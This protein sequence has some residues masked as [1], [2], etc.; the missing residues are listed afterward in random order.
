MRDALTSGYGAAGLRGDVLAGLVV[1]VVAL[2][3]SMGLA[4]ASGVAPQHGLYTAIVAGGLIALLGGSRVQVSGPTA[5]FVV[6]LSP[7]AARLGLS[8]LLMSTLLAGLL[9]MA[10]GVARLGKWIEY[11]PYPVTI[12]FTAGIAVVIATLQLEGLLALDVPSMPEHFVERVG[13]LA[14]ALPTLHV[15]DLAIGALTL[16]VLVVWPRV[17]RK[18]PAPLVALIVA[19]LAAVA[20]H[21]VL[22]EFDVVTIADRFGSTASDGTPSAGIP[23]LLPPFVLPWDLPGAHG[24]QFA[25][26]WSVL[27]TLMPSAFAIAMLGA[28][29]SLLSAVVADGMIGSAHDPDAELFAQGVGNF[30]APFFGGIAA[31]GAI[32]RTATNVRSGARSPLAAVVHALVV[33]LA[34]LA[35]AP[36]LGHLP[37]A[38]LSALLLMVA[39]NMSEAK[40]FVHTLRTSPA[41]DVVVLLSCFGLTVAF[42]MVVS[43]SVG[44]VLASLLFMKRM[45][46]LAEVRMVEEHHPLLDRKL[47]EEVVYYEIA[48]P[49]FFGAAHRATSALHV[50]HDRAKAVVLDIRSVPAMDATGLVNLRSA[51]AR[52]HKD[53]LFVVVAGAQ[54]Q[55][56]QLL[57]RAGVAEQ[58]GRLAISGDVER[59]LDL[60]CRHVESRS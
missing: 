18:L 55:P 59:A 23:Q 14:Q 34:V 31:T 19:A 3:L 35:L 21:G 50:V 20:V 12:G 57:A 45:A 39:W 30:V 54:T 17:T 56:A 25:L 13:A 37:M 47:P 32:A 5:A 53:G 58:P 27:R 42:D 33:L 26:S 40:H 11:I 36:L 22:P 7:I 60:A 16:G 43:V 38:A 9:L 2:P 1:G 28:I 10:M 44:V 29:E 52:L 24:E 41:S 4:I 49:L 48:G 51:I 46:E 15:D 8:G 6:V